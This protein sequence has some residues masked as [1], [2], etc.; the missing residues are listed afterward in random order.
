MYRLGSMLYTQRKPIRRTLWN[1]NR[2]QKT[3][4]TEVRREKR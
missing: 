1:P 4:N 2:K 3:E